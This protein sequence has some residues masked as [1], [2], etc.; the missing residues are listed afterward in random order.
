MSWV[1]LKNEYTL[2]TKKAREKKPFLK[3]WIRFTELVNKSSEKPPLAMETLISSIKKLEIN[4]KKNQI[5]IFDHGCGA[6]LKAMYLAALGYKNVY[7]VDVGEV[8]YINILLKKI[9][10][11]NE[12]RFLKTDGKRVPF[13]NSKFD[14]IISSQVVEHLKEEHIYTYYQ[15]EGRLLKKNGLV[16]HEVPHLFMP[17]E[18][19]TRLWLIH[20]LPYFFK[21][22]LY[23]VVQSIR[24]KKNLL[25]KGTF[26]ADLYT[27][28]FLILRSPNFHKSML[29]KYIGPFDDITVSRLLKKTDFSSYDKDSNLKLRKLIQNIIML[30]IFGKFFVKIIK[31]FFILQTLSKKK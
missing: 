5:T 18:A 23:A 4:K 8:N 2:I 14:F 1:E 28:N 7:G 11:I 15:E 27:K 12:Q 16:Y 31:N 13:K 10:N 3:N 26:Y 19:H 17:Y 22:F 6:G 29:L 25:N 21:P 9:F 30:P 20:L 24:K